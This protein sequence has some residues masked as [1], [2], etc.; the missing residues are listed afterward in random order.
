M[1]KQVTSPVKRFPGTVTL[2]D[3]LTIPQAITWERALRDAGNLDRQ[4]ATNA[5]FIGIYVPGVA[6]V[7]LEWGLEGFTPDP[8]QTTP[9]KAVDELLAWLIREITALY[10]DDTDP[11]D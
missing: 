6:A 5:D 7:V 3:Y 1:P 9:R 4:T 11:N 2:P 10:G 8:F